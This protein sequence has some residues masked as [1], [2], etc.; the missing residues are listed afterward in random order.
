[1]GIRDGNGF[2]NSFADGEDKGGMIFCIHFGEEE[3]FSEVSLQNG[4][5]TRRNRG[6]GQ[7]GGD[8]LGDGVVYSFDRH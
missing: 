4:R 2:V 6:G 3:K 1:M 8:E 5:A 7:R